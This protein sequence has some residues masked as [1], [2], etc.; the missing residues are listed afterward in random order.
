MDVVAKAR[1]KFG[2]ENKNEVLNYL[3]SK[4]GDEKGKRLLEEYWD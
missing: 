4:Y 1:I 3:K 2:S